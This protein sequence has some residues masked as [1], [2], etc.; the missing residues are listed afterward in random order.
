[1]D[2]KKIGDFLKSLRQEKGLTQTQLADILY[3][4]NRSISRWEQGNG[5][6]DIDLL[7][8]LAHFYD[9][10]L[11]EILDG[12]RNNMDNKI[13]STVL[14]AAELENDEKKKMIRIIQVITLISLIFLLISYLL[15]D[16]LGQ[17]DIIDFIF[18]FGNGLTFGTLVLI[19]IITS[20]WGIKIKELKKRITKND[21]R[22]TR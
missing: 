8:K 18:G 2:Q 11:E 20:R 12:Q 13:D 6:P 17:N 10:K 4:S 19:L 1:M 16:S 15:S 7:L 21:K 22:S 5:L 9:V 14:K 3:V